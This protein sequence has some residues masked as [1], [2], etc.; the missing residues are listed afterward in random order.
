MLGI[1]LIA[2]I[3]LAIIGGAVGLAT[4]VDEAGLEIITNI[5]GIPFGI[6]LTVINLAIFNK[7]WHDLGRT[8]MW[9]LLFF[10]PIVGSV[11]YIYLGIARG[12][13]EENQYGPVPG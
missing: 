13:A 10:I 12:Q 3:I 4:E 11:L 6:L 5:I 9:S 8:G 2:A 1:G 7:R